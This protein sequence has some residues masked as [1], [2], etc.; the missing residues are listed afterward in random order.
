MEQVTVNL[1]GLSNADQEAITN[2]ADNEGREIADVLVDLIRA[3]L[4]GVVHNVNTGNV[5]GTSI[6]AGRVEGEFRF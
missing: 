6:Q 3:G 5:S 1:G 4:R 2:R